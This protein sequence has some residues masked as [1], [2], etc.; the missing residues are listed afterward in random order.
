MADVDENII[1]APQRLS[2]QRRA[3]DINYNQQQRFN[4][5][6]IG[7]NQPLA[8]TNHFRDSSVGPPVR[9]SM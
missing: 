8:S 6:S 7:F 1:Q 4:G 9:S 5:Q 3:E 2:M